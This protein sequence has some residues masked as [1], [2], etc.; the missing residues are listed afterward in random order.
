M[1]FLRR[2]HLD[3]MNSERNGAVQI[4]R[5]NGYDRPTAPPPLAKSQVLDA[6]ELLNF[7]PDKLVAEA[8]SFLRW[9]QIVHE[10]EVRNTINLSA[11]VDG[12]YTKSKLP[13][14][15]AELNGLAIPA[16]L[17]CKVTIHRFHLFIQLKCI[18][19]FRL[20]AVS[21]KCTPNSRI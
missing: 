1:P 5:L 13:Q 21:V 11:V 15:V 10:K 17:E 19:F 8:K 18:S 16:M 4:K 7:L 3:T 12:V 20:M 14:Q 9:N 2:Q 6:T